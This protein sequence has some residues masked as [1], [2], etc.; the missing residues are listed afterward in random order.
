M[1]AASNSRLA[2]YVDQ[3]MQ[4]VDKSGDCWLWTGYVNESGYG[5]Y[6][7]PAVLGVTRNGRAH[8]LVYELHRGEIPAGMVLDHL[9]RV[10]HC[11]NPDHLEPVT[12]QENIKRSPLAFRDKCTSGHPYTEGSFY[13]DRGARVCKQ[14]KRDRAA[15]YAAKFDRAN[16][17]FT[18]EHCGA[19]VKKP[20]RSGHLKSQHPEHYRPRQRSQGMTPER[21][22]RKLQQQRDRRRAAAN[23]RGYAV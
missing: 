22:A 17:V 7:T 14:C 10:R 6:S 8:C 5:M 19:E 16:Q 23:Q 15:T 20:S 18:C 21:K 2:P 13:L 3:I 1:T 4:R 9:C 12:N 11:V